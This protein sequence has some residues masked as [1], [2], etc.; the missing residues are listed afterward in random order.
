MENAN[1]TSNSATFDIKLTHKGKSLTLSNITTKTTIAQLHN[2]TRQSFDISED[3]TII[4]LLH[5]GK[6]LEE[7]QQPAFAT[8]P[9]KTPKI[10]IMS[11]PKTQIQT[12]NSKKSDPLLRGFDNETKPPSSSQKCT[13]CWGSSH[14][15]QNRHYKFVRFDTVHQHA[16]GTRPTSTTPH[17]FRAMDLLQKLATDPGVVKILTDRELVVNTLGE[18]DPIDDRIMQK[19]QA[20][21][22]CL[23]GYNTNRGLRIDL[24]LRTDDLEGFREYKEL[25]CTLI[26]EL[27]HNWVGEH[28]ALFFANYGSMR[29]EYLVE[30]LILYQRGYRVAGG[31]S[32]A[33]V[34]GVKEECSGGME[35]VLDVVLRELRG[36]TM[37]YGVNMMAVQPVVEARWRELNEEM[38]ER[39]K[40]GGLTIGGGNNEKDRSVEGRRQRALAAAERRL[41]ELKEND[42]T[43]GGGEKSN[44]SGSSQKMDGKR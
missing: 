18:M 14:S 3:D 11:T 26:H 36:E 25:V 34:A 38:G 37:R 12:L 28:D 42:G 15:T 33:E 16:F 29:V 22:M 39:M 43:G 44:G 27:S 20:E 10:V 19:K 32:C 9:T 5:K 23:L 30:H 8:I 35:K 41:K 31:R 1:N 4:K 40:E 17:A 13:C 21:G 6:K 2:L 7:E 24:K